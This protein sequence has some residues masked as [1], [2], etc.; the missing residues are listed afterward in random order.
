MTAKR[1]DNVRQ[2]RKPFILNRLRSKVLS[3]KSRT[4]QAMQTASITMILCRGTKS[5]NR[6]RGTPRKIPAISTHRTSFI[7]IFL[8]LVVQKNG[9]CPLIS[10]HST[11]LKI[12]TFIACHRSPAL[13]CDSHPDDRGP[14]RWILSKDD[15]CRNVN[16]AP[17]SRIMPLYLASTFRCKQSRQKTQECSTYSSEK[18]YPFFIEHIQLPD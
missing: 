3:R 18:I 8:T 2:S 11:A 17:S 12:L 5:P 10:F 9:I 7:G 6:K 14:A 16:S 15:R 4:R 1:M 13:R